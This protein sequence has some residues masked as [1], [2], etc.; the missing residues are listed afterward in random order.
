MNNELVTGIGMGNK[1]SLEVLRDAW[2]LRE[3][4]ALS[5]GQRFKRFCLF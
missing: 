5:E 2:M 1:E 3:V 4:R